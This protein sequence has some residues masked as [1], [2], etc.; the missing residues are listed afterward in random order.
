MSHRADEIRKRLAK[1]RKQRPESKRT[2]VQNAQTQNFPAWQTVKEQEKHKLLPDYE[3]QTEHPPEFNGRHPLISAHS[4]ILKCLL[5]ACLVLISAIAYK[6]DKQ[7]LSQIKPA[8]AQTFQKEFQF[9]AVSNWFVSSFGN[10]LAFLTPGTKKKD[11]QVAVSQDMAVPAAG[12]IQQNFQNNGEG[13]V[14]ETASEAIDSVKE[15]Y[16]M[17]VSKDKKTG[18]TVKVQHA[19]NTSSIYGRL[20]D[21]NVSLYD[22]VDKGKK[23]GSIKLNDK[24]KGQYYFAIQDGDKFIDPIQVITFDE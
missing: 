22:F 21:V 1:R 8:I 20:K 4:I 9:A 2:F 13:V 24:S 6:T 19:D 15:G 18:L 14:V 16:I 7:P 23:I 11:G 10:P 12:K 17:E 5:A 3:Y